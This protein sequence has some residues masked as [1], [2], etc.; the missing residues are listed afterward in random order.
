MLMFDEGN[1]TAPD[2]NSCCGWK[3][4]KTA[5]DN[6]LVQNA[7]GTFSPDTSIH[8]YAK[9]NQGHGKSIFGVLTNQP[10]AP[11]AGSSDNDAYSHFSF[12]RTLQD[13]FVLSDPAKD[14]VV[15]EPLE[16]HREVHRRRT[17]ST[18]RSSPAAP[19]RTSTRCVR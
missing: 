17:S 19:T 18:C 16:V 6:P 3:A 5:L 14:G 7:D 11:Q 9:G 4:G 15:H 8:N 13:M 10:S 1:A 12:V 2:F